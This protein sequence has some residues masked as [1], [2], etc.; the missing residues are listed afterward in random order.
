MVTHAHSSEHYA[1]AKKAS[2]PE[3]A[4]LYIQGFEFDGTVCFRKGAASGPNAF[5]EVAEGIESYSP[6]L[7]IDLENEERFFDLGNIVL[8]TS[9]DIDSN[10][11]GAV[12]NF[13][14]CF[15]NINLKDSNIKLLTLGG[16]HSI[17]IA[18]IKKYLECY[19]DLVVV[20]LDAHADLRDGYLGHHYSH[21]SIIRR[22]LDLFGAEHELIQYGIRSG[23]M[24]EY[25]EMKSRKSL[26]LS[27]SEFLERIKLIP[28]NRPIYLTLDLDF[29]DP[30]F[31]PGTGTPE[32]GGEDFHCFISLVKILKDKNFVG[33]DIV[34]LAPEI[35]PTGNSSVFGTKVLRE[36]AAS[37]LLSSKNRGEG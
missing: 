36:T 16:E 6:Y 21:A 28:N 23:T 29:F 31:L 1:Y 27:R 25:D 8:P 11:L 20:H 2:T 7:N 22:S 37:L 18:P 14:Q 19:Q 32:A 26:C 24:E 33:A 4:G 15:K 10:F 3:G 13:E 5:R 34:E 35:D 17:S 12:K 30:A 9:E